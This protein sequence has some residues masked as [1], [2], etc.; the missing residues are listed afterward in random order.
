VFG[1]DVWFGVP[2]LDPNTSWTVACTVR[3][4]LVEAMREMATDERPVF[5]EA[6]PAEA[7]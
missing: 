3:E 1:I 6:T 5:P 2:C 7:A 4:R